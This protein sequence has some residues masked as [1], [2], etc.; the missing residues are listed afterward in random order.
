MIK[1][2]LTWITTLYEGED[3]EI[4][5]SIFKDD[6]LIKEE[7]FFEDYTKPA[8]CGL[9][10]TKRLLS[11]LK[12]YRTNDIKIII[13][14]GSLFDLLEGKSQTPDFEV[15]SLARKV[16][17]EL[18]KFNHVQIKNTSGNHLE[19]KKWNDILTPENLI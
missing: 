1:A 12:D 8:F 15:Q 6:E 11:D 19:T 5:Y 14:D 9:L 7:S 18:D 16:R 10:A 13:N 17:K 2:Y 4:R 3:I